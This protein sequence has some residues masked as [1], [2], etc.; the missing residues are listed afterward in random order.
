MIIG[1]LLA[2]IGIGVSSAIVPLYISE[3][4]PTEIRGTLGS[5]NQLFICIGILAALVAGL[6]LAG[7][8]LWW[9]SMF[10]VALIPSVLL[11]LGMAFSPESPRWL[12]QQGRISD[13]EVSI[14]R[15][16]GKER[17]SEVMRDLAAAGQGSTE[18]E[19][20]WFDLFSSRYWKSTYY[21]Y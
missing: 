21:H 15:L 5:V 10:G 14:R 3:I 8:P 4:S 16:Y 7:N 19:A 13:A 20:G 9:R 1:R 18:P 2:G 11:A 12:Y 6:P 17:V